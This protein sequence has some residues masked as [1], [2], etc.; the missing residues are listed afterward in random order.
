MY[1]SEDIRPSRD[2]LSISGGKF[3]SIFR[4]AVV[5][6]LIRSDQQTEK[7]CALAHRYAFEAKS[8][9]DQPDTKETIP[10]DF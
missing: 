7:W 4:D 2:V 9:A 10:T 3:P 1:V 8:Q 5:Q 6:T